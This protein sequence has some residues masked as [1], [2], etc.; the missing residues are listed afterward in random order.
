VQY[1]KN[2]EY[3]RKYL[4][5]LPEKYQDDYVEPEESFWKWGNINVHYDFKYSES[6]KVNII[7][8]HGAGGNGS[9][10]LQY[11]CNII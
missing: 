4:S 7:L 2:R 5:F 11:L 9:V 3:W 8:L 1:Y 6:N 10:M